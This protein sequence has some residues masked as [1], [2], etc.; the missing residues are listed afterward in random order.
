MKVRSMFGNL[1]FSTARLSAKLA[2]GLESVGTSCIYTYNDGT[3]LFPFIVTNRHVVAGSDRFSLMFSSGQGGLGALGGGTVVDF[4]VAESDWV[5]HPDPSIDLACYPMAGAVED[6]KRLGKELFF[7]SLDFGML[8][9][10]VQFSIIDAVEDVILIG[11]PSGLYDPIHLLPIVRKGITATP[12]EIDYGGKREFLIDASVFP[13][14]S[15]SPVFLDKM[16]SP[17]TREDGTGELVGTVFF[18]GVVSK[19]YTR[20]DDASVT[21]IDVPT[22]TSIAVKTTQMIDI[23]VVIK[24]H[25]VHEMIEHALRTKG[26]II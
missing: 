17:F 11:Y 18:I 7:R 13:G 4:A 5:F 6:G 9:R 23:G 19:V 25:C 20:N 26:F 14:S 2:S 1:I 8:I 3:R 12:L 24:A 21:T 16:H 22:N 10:A 15:G